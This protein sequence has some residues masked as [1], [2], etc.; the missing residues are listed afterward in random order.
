MDKSYRDTIL[1]N[2]E[3]WRVAY[4]S[5]FAVL[6]P[7]AAG[8]LCFIKQEQHEICF[9]EFHRPCCKHEAAT[10]LKQKSA[11]IAWWSSYQNCIR[12]GLATIKSPLSILREHFSSTSPQVPG[13]RP[14]QKAAVS[15]INFDDTLLDMKNAAA[16]FFF[17]PK[18][19]E[20]P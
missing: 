15:R 12:M 13:P 19:V 8:V 17:G 7:M 1:R 9:R 6:S 18:H 5:G 4:F 10:S 3:Q 20:R 11:F 16:T 14:F 2:F